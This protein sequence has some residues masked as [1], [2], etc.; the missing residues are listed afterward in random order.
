MVSKR[1]K[2]ANWLFVPDPSETIYDGSSDSF[3]RRIG[4]GDYHEKVAAHDYLISTMR[5]R[6][7][8]EVLAVCRGYRRCDNREYDEA[9]AVD[10]ESCP[11]RSTRCRLGIS[12]KHAQTR[13]VGR[14]MW[15]DSQKLR[16]Q[17]FC[18]CVHNRTC[19][20]GLQCAFSKMPPRLRTGPLR[21]KRECTA[22]LRCF[23]VARDEFRRTV[24]AIAVGAGFLG[25]PIRNG[26]CSERKV[27]GFE[28]FRR[29]RVDGFFPSLA[30][31]LYIGTTK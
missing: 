16:S 19:R 30:W 2:P 22:L 26:L 21:G 23:E 24:K 6:M 11:D 28:S 29:Q 17:R 18:R 1:E 7:S 20:L 9:E 3:R 15:G 4:V 10:R 31:L 5:G 12:P 27:S 13:L 14:Q 8:F 25:M